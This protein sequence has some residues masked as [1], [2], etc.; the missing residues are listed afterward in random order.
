MCDEGAIQTETKV[1]CRELPPNPKGWKSFIRAT[2]GGIGSYQDGKKGN[3]IFNQVSKC[4]SYKGF[5]LGFGRVR[6]QNDDEP[7][8]FIRIPSNTDEEKLL[9]FIENVWEL[10]R[11]SLLFSITGSGVGDMPHD[12]D[13]QNVVVDLICFAER[14]DAWITTGGWDGGIMKLFGDVV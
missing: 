8:P 12:D 13:L 1:P 6:F 10:P 4:T 7:K 5:G 9:Y 2:G 3:R 14:S 11:P